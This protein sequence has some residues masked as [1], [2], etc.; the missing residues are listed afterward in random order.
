ML[1][2][3][4]RSLAGPLV[5]CAVCAA[6]L[7]A[8]QSVSPAPAAGAAA[9]ERW[10]LAR[11][12][13]V[14]LEKSMVVE[15]A[16]EEVALNRARR[17]EAAWARFPSLTWTST[18]SP[19]GAMKGDVFNTTTP[20]NQYF[21]FDGVFQQHKLDI[22]LPLFTFGKLRNA[23]KAAEAGVRAAEHDVDRARAEVVRDVRKA[24]WAVKVSAEVLKV[25]EEGWERIVAAEKKLD[26]L[27]AKKAKD[28]SPL[29]RN[30]LVTFTSDVASRREEAVAFAALSKSAL[31]VVVGMPEGANLDA[32]TAPLHVAAASVP[33]LSQLV[34]MAMSGR[35]E[36]KSL[37]A[38]VDVRRSLADLARSYY[39]PDFFAAGQVGVARC[40]VC[41]DQTN[42]FVFDPFNLDLYGGALGL[43]FSL[44]IPQ[45]IAR[46]RQADAELRKL[47]AQ[48]ARA[49]EGIK[50]EVRK[51]FLEWVQAREQAAIITRGRKSAQGWL[52]Q[53]TINFST[54]LMKLR[55]LTD[56]LGAWF[57]F[58]LEELRSVFSLNVAI[59]ELS[60][61]VG[62]DLFTAT[63]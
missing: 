21:G 23:K 37:G 33:P 50:L 36:L 27:I 16:R 53:A 56:A 4:P 60:R 51:A 46:V 2:F 7:A 55:D 14:A 1:N 29:D 48:R 6:S 40:N 47:G 19:M 45:K 42:P 31:R 30:R 26:E 59:A 58:R 8:A 25:V 5:A 13:A 39:Y 28:V 9:P 34:E 3:V 17:M 20:T 62:R 18:A 43:R 24:Y 32:D 38:L 22:G 15:A 49:I 54:G 41:A 35:P 10:S 57:K 44:D 52:F 61:V 12:E 63:P 11:F